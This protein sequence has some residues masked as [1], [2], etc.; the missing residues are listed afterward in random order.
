MPA[1]PAM[2]S[3][4]SMP[5]MPSIP[6]IPGLRKGGAEGELG[7]EGEA[8]AAAAAGGVANPAA[9]VGGEEDDKSRYIRYGP[10]NFVNEEILVFFLKQKKKHKSLNM[11][12]L[13][14]WSLQV[15]IF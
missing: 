3:M 8:A 1:M 4:P 2:P 6:N 9:A 13:Y 12:Q 7:M 10:H 15:F 14:K 5:A 11:F